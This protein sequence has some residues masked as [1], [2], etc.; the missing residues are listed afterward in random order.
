MSGSAEAAGAP[1]NRE[2]SMAKQETVIL[3]V[4]T[5]GLVAG[6]I[7]GCGETP[8]PRP[9]R[10]RTG[11]ETASTEVGKSAS[12]DKGAAPSAAVEGWATIKGKVVWGGASLPEMPTLDV[13]KD[14]QHC[15]A[16]GAL[17]DETFVVDAKTKGVANVFAYLRKPRG[18]HPDLPKNAKDV[19]EK[20]LKDFEAAT[21]V[22]CDEASLQKAFADKAKR[23]EIIATAKKM[24]FPV[25]DQDHCK[26]LPHAMTAREGQKVL[27][28]N[29][30]PIAHNVKMSSQTGVNDGNPNMSPE[31][32][33]L[34]DWKNDSSMMSIEC[35]IHPWMKMQAM[36]FDHPYYAVTG[37]DGSFEL[38]NVPAGDVTLLVRNQKSNIDPQKG[39]KGDAKGVTLSLKA[40]EVKDLGEIKYSGE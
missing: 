34:L 5:V 28:L 2:D 24:G 4:C 26:Y 13:Q 1:S 18:I 27:V 8:Q 25:I 40:G 29:Y 7:M 23:A 16:A 11:G 33:L 36:V 30:E 35:G 31:T 15:L 20:F 12:S 10:Q 39:G 32:F 19:Q 6:L 9:N 21:K 38:K 37:A 14:K 17:K 3:G 22:K